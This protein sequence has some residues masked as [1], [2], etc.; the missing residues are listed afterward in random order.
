MLKKLISV[1]GAIVMLAQFAV[2]AFAQ[3]P[4]TD[5][6]PVA[7]EAIEAAEEAPA[8]GGESSVEP[9]AEADGEESPAEEETQPAADG[10]TLSGKLEAGDTGASVKGKTVKLMKAGAQV[11]SKTTGSNGSFSFSG[12]EM[13]DY[14]LMVD[15]DLAGAKPYRA[16]SQA[17]TVDNT[18]LTGRV[19]RLQK[20]YSFDFAV[21]GEINPGVTNVPGADSLIVMAD[22]E[23][24]WA[25]GGDE[26]T[27]NVWLD[28]RSSYTSGVLT[29]VDIAPN[30][31]LTDLG[32]TIEKPENRSIPFVAGVNPTGRLSFSFT[33]PEEVQRAEDILLELEYDE[34]A[35]QVSMETGSIK[36]SESAVTFTEKTAQSKTLDVTLLNLMPD[37]E[38]TLSWS[39]SV[40]GTGLSAAFTSWGG[41]SG[42]GSRGSLKISATDQVKASDGD[43]TLTLASGGKTAEIKVTVAKD[44][45]VKGIRFDPNALYDPDLPSMGKEIELI[46]G[47]PAPQQVGYYFYSSLYPLREANYTPDADKEERLVAVSS[48]EKVA[49]VLLNET[50]KKVAI[51]PV[52]PGRVDISV[53]LMRGK[54]ELFKDT[55]SLLVSKPLSGTK[56]VTITPAEHEDDMLVGESVQLGTQLNPA[57]AVLSRQEWLV[58]N[59]AA[60]S[61]TQTGKLTALAAAS[62]VT[63]T[64]KAWGI[65]QE[66]A[67]PT[68]ATWTINIIDKA[69]GV[70]ILDGEGQ[71]VSS[72]LVYLKDGATQDAIDLSALVSP[73]DNTGSLVRDEDAVIEWS[74]SGSAVS[75]DWDKDDPAKNG[76]ATITPVKTGTA[77]LT[78]S[79]KSNKKL[80]ATLTVKVVKA[81]AADIEINDATV[82]TEKPLQVGKTHT[83]KAWNVDDHKTPGG[84]FEWVSSN[85]AV[86]TVSEKGVI[87]GVSPGAFRISIFI[88]GEEVDYTP[89][90][91][92]VMNVTALGFTHGDITLAAGTYEN[93]LPALPVSP[94]DL[95]DPARQYPFMVLPT[96]F[97]PDLAVQS[98]LVWKQSAVRGASQPDVDIDYENNKVT[99][100]GSGKVKLTA[101]DPLTKKSASFTLTVGSA[102][103]V[104][105]IAIQPKTVVKE[106]KVGKSHTLKVDIEPTEAAAYGYYWY[107]S[108]T[109]IISVSPKGVIKALKASDDP[110]GI[111]VVS[112]ADPGKTASIQVYA[113]EVAKSVTLYKQADYEQ[114]GKKAK[115]GT[116]TLDNAYNNI[117]GVIA[118][119]NVTVTGGQWSYSFSKEDIVSLQPEQ[120]FV[121]GQEG[122]LLKLS[123]NKPGTTKLTVGYGTRKATLTIKCVE[124]ADNTMVKWVD[125]GDLSN[126]TDVY[127]L[128]AKRPGNTLDLA[129]RLKWAEGATQKTPAW[130]SRNTAVATVDKKGKVTGKAP[131]LT[132]ITAT[133]PGTGMVMARPVRVVKDK[134]NP[135]DTLLATYS[136]Y[137]GDTGAWE[138]LG[139]SIQGL[140]FPM[141]VNKA[142]Y[143]RVE[144][145]KYS[146]VV[147]FSDWECIILTQDTTLEPDSYVSSNNAIA[148]TEAAPDYLGANTFK[149]ITGAKA[150]KATLTVTAGAHTDKIPLQTRVFPASLED[151]TLKANK[152]EL[153]AGGTLDLAVGKA[154]SLLAS[155]ANSKTGLKKLQ[156]TLEPNSGLA[157]DGRAMPAH[158]VLSLDAAK[159]RIT[160]IAPG[161]ATIK[162]AHADLPSRSF[163]FTVKVFAPVAGL[164]MLQNNITLP[165]YRYGGNIQAAEFHQKLYVRVDGLDWMTDDELDIYQGYAGNIQWS[166]SNPTVAG[167]RNIGNGNI[168]SQIAGSYDAADRSLNSVYFVGRAPG[169]ATITAT[170][171]E[172]GLKASFKLKVTGHVADVTDVKMQKSELVL[173]PGASTTLK[174][175]VL[176]EDAGNTALV[177]SLATAAQDP[178][179]VM[180]ETGIT[181]NERTGKLTVAKT[182]GFARL[183]VVATSLNH[184]VVGGAVKPSPSAVCWV[185][186]RTAPTKLVFDAAAYSTLVGSGA[187]SM[188]EHLSATP[189]AALD[190]R[191][192]QLW[193]SLV[194]TVANPDLFRVGRS[195]DDVLLVPQERAG[196]R[197][198]GTTILTVREPGGKKASVPVSVTPLP[199][200]LPEPGDLAVKS[201]NPLEVT[202]TWSA[203]EAVESYELVSQ[204]DGSSGSHTLTVNGRNA[205]DNSL[206]AGEGSLVLEDGQ[207]TYTSRR[208][209]GS[210][211][212]TLKAHF[213]DYDSTDPSATKTTQANQSITVQVPTT[214]VA[215]FV[216]TV[217]DANITGVPNTTD[218][219]V[220]LSWTALAATTGASG[221]LVESKDSEGG[222]YQTYWV[223]K[224]LT[225]SFNDLPHLREEFKKEET[226]F[227]YTR[228]YQ[229]CPIY[230]DLLDKDGNLMLLSSDEYYHASANFV[231]TPKLTVNKI[232]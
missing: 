223:F 99:L 39:P 172:T 36:L 165:V 166:S 62:G 205:T 188:K 28:G 113:T 213:K 52:G 207:Y 74:R 156:Y 116:L 180:P 125:S 123:Y 57:D 72:L 53:V 76:K 132:I 217:T 222:P 77:T 71:P 143:V 47:T 120:Y 167:F 228:Y 208:E 214:T 44:E 179:V 220:L 199:P 141:D 137:D 134:A 73:Y 169:E 75:L 183:K 104:I 106:L 100:S 198:R 118:L 48:N 56:P 142:R 226:G 174:A 64:L 38:P 69:D 181:I 23:P 5:D 148:R 232:S 140:S 133:F 159:G 197:M 111:T 187:I 124:Y 78:A 202:V 61:I 170:N 107:S 201:V 20:P 209:P 108:A 30:A 9:A 212:Y 195:G 160:A 203:L 178:K 82:L 14:T 86:A 68:E 22:V 88:N 135:G 32:V 97:D 2:P 35:T 12:V 191:D 29:D 80:K 182:V 84:Y 105:G 58:S 49:T 93:L 204:A 109:D 221:Y 33:L 11:A 85:P 101:T 59:P 119:P 127:T 17:V 25:T 6:P 3:A 129:A 63:V 176:P 7:E 27:V 230:S 186:V 227:S 83:I 121:D 162:V 177:W 24:R 110:V 13:G 164:T 193:D 130:T 41:S 95:E 185:T 90:M 40:A 153:P 151:I 16:V 18:N 31:S 92:V 149:L 60:A 51:T 55:I 15:A 150:G 94:A 4:I 91:E 98:R 131:G 1:F 43:Y 215:D 21:F 112:A 211:S 157:P 175:Q 147:E 225:V 37:N 46:G 154:A 26:V 155:F 190:A 231:A 189:A 168:Q 161:T 114:S 103:P 138:R 229:I 50:D 206:G 8:A 146:G 128:T 163:S 152:Q 89:E 158:R 139:G 136:Y 34:A 192:T 45:A 196:E 144:Y 216:G 19:L 42:F 210:Y 102:Q 70:A 117:A 218:G 224:G 96:P 126:Q 200:T 173:R 115:Q 219:S 122:V 66:T 10:Y 184:T 65:N 171:V 194:W 81:P 67:N 79:A 54:T 145:R 87:K